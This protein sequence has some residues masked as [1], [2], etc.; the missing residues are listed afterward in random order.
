MILDGEV[1]FEKLFMD[2]EFGDLFC[3][4]KALESVIKMPTRHI[5]DIRIISLDR[6]NIF[7]ILIQTQ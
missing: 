5:T 7:D 6:I 2:N 1:E 4:G 3:S